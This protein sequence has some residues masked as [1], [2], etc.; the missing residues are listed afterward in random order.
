[1][2]A[3]DWGDVPTWLG[4]MFAAGAAGAAVW[5]LA[6]QRAQIKEQREFIAEQSAN[7]AL[8]RAELEASIEERRREQARQ[9]RFEVSRE[10]ASEGRDERGQPIASEQYHL[11]GHVRNESREPLREVTVRVGEVNMPVAWEFQD[12]TI[13]R[14][15]VRM[16]DSETLTP[17]L[18]IAAET[19]VTFGG[20]PYQGDL[21]DRPVLLFTDNNGVR[22]RL[23]EHGDLSRAVQP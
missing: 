20:G 18:L 2:S 8:E 16:R 11:H 7:L 4:A 9:V 22:W 6:S 10:A 21:A 5:T 1:M 13:N 12:A 15:R 19:N 17:P 3:V 14:T 23:D